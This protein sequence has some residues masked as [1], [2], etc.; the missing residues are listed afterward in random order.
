MDKTKQSGPWSTEQI[1]A[2][3]RGARIPLRLALTGSDGSPFVTSLWFCFEQD[4]IWCATARDSYLA[5]Q[6]ARDP[7]CGFEIAPESPPYFGIRGQGDIELFPEQGDAWLARL[8]ERYLGDQPS[9]FSR[10]LL[11]QDR[12]ETAFAIRARTLSTWDYRERMGDTA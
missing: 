4:R 1:H 8:A 12:P 10:W 7:R 6:I 11:A 9:D 5:R 3:L 2:Y